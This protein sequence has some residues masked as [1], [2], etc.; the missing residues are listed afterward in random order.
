MFRLWEI[1][2]PPIRPTRED[3]VR[4]REASQRGCVRGGVACQVLGEVE[5]LGPRTFRKAPRLRRGLQRARPAG[6]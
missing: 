1:V 4:C 5:G 6:R 2:S 3:W